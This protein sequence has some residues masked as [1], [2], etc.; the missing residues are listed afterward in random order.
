VKDETGQLTNTVVLSATEKSVVLRGYAGT[1][2]TITVD[3]GQSTVSF[4]ANTKIF[5]AKVTADAATTPQ[6]VDGDPG[7]TLKVVLRTGA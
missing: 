4:D 3:G 5:S 2:P 6:M 7:M 1:A